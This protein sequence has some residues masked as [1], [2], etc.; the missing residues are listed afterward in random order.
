M[1]GITCAP[2][3]SACSLQQHSRGC[4]DLGS[5]CL[6]GADPSPTRIQPHWLDSQCQCLGFCRTSTGTL[7]HIQTLFFCNRSTD[8][9]SANSSGMHRVLRQSRSGVRHEVLGPH[10][11]R[12][13]PL[14]TTSS[15]QTYS[16]TLPN[17]RIGSHTRVIFQGFTGKQVGNP[18]A[19]S[20]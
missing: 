15:L 8:S 1:I 10:P 16:E 12:H 11:G 18:P 19:P 13:R 20:A 17:L 3:H 7:T 9:W 5:T 4:G 2:P 6:E 14:C